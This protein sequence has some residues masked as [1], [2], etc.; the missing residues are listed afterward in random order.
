MNV[1]N[2]R[3]QSA[4]YVDATKGTN[5]FL[6]ISG[7]SKHYKIS[8]F[9]KPKFV[10]SADDI[11]LKVQPGEVMGLVGESGSGKSTI[12][13]LITRQVEPTSGAIKID[14][15][16]WLALRGENLRKRRRD[17]QMIFQDPY[18]A[19]D[20]RMKIGTS[21]GA[22]LAFHG[23]SDEG[24]R[25]RRVHAMLNEVGLDA[26]FAD[27]YPKECSGGQ[28]QRVVVGR[29]LLLEPKLLICDEPTSALDASMKTQILNLFLE[30][31]ERRGITMIMISHDLRVVRHIC[32]RIAVMYLGRLIEIAETEHLFEHP[33]HPY[34]Q[35]LIASSKLEETGLDGAGQ[36]TGELPSPIN[37]P[38][39]CGFHPRCPA[40]RQDC[41]DAAP[42]LKLGHA[43]HYVRCRHW[44][45][46]QTDSAT[47]AEVSAE[48]AGVKG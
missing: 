34:T 39:G 2:M 22:P 15:M 4:R 33:C 10:R 36:L 19:L 20:P 43:D 26:S 48:S 14:G 25:Q 42:R 9:P 8:A 3:R 13:K 5:G 35:A 11:S 30:L 29:A 23:V 28:L 1:D 37:P 21:M 41:T 38:T 17:V 45:E 16:D 31:K 44:Q 12:A 47:S 24:E 6:E 32:D 27:R 46:L 40:A 18:S 7:L